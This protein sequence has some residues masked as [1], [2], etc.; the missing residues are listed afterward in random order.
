MTSAL[1]QLLSCYKGHQKEYETEHDD[2]EE[3]VKAE[4]D[5]EDQEDENGRTEGGRGGQAEMGRN[6]F[7]RETIGPSDRDLHWLC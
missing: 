5:V 2:D 6:I 4:D 7:K 3:G 1:L